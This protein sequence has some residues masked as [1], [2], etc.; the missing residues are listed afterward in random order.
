MPQWIQLKGHLNL[1]LVSNNIVDWLPKIK[2]RS[3][4]SFSIISH[5]IISMNGQSREKEWED[6]MQSVSGPSYRH[7][8]LKQPWSCFY[9]T[10]A[11]L[12]IT[13]NVLEHEYRKTIA[14]NSDQALGNIF[15][16]LLVM[17]GSYHPFSRVIR[18]CVG[19]IG[20]RQVIDVQHQAHGILSVDSEV[21]RFTSFAKH[22]IIWLALYST[23]RLVWA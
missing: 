6:H 15:P 14:I 17:S 1:H 2:S 12:Y 11:T 16:R 21:L 19:C 18:H 8:V 22:T 5:Y 23:W 20:Q 10:F 4:T 3:K 7:Q 13:M 9:F